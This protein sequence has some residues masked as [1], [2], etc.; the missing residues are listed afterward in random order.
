MQDFVLKSNDP[1]YK[2]TLNEQIGNKADA[3]S[4]L[5]GNLGL[6]IMDID[7]VTGQKVD[8]TGILH[9]LAVQ[10]VQNNWS[11]SQIQEHI[12]SNNATIFTRGGT[13]GSKLDAVKNQALLYG[14]TIDPGYEKII[15]ND[16]MDPNSGRDASYY[17]Y[18]FQQQAMN[19]TWKP[20]AQAI[21]DGQ[22]L[23]SVTN[24]YRKT[25]S[26]LLEVDPSQISW[27]DL[28]KGIIDPNTGNA[29]TNA[30]FTAQV[31]QNKMWQYTQNAKDTYTGLGEDL[32]REFGFIG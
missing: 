27:N 14:V 19:G 29:R 11:T 22:D 23:Y 24:N 32:M 21:K 2:G 6:D 12:A 28:E 3:I 7:P 31:K 30:D 20:F 15:A 1:R 9:G 5:M 10:A 8:R 13:I 4:T 18:Q 16:L 17:K 26:T 25:M